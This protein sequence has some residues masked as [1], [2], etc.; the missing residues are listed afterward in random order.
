MDTWRAGFFDHAPLF[1]PLAVH[2]APLAIA[3]WPTLAAMQAVLDARGVV[4]GGG[5]P[6][7][8][9]APAPGRARAFE[10]RYEARIFLKGELAVRSHNWHDLF[11]VLVWLAF[12][13][14][15][16]AIN[17]R[18]YRALTDPIAP[19]DQVRANRG[20]TQDA[21]TLFD[22]G[23]VI[24]ASSEPDLLEMLRAFEWKRLFWRER[25]RVVE[26]MR[27]LLF[28][29]AVYEKALAPFV[30]ITGR[31][32]LFAVDP[33]LYALPLQAQMGALDARLA[34]LIADETALNTTR[35]LAPVP[36][37]GVPGWWPANSTEA[38]Y[39]NTDYFRAGRARKFS[40][41]RGVAR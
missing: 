1:A 31:G 28:G 4:G 8:V 9:V 17:A 20:P 18:H 15:K 40:A 21:L 11:N 6:L 27:W 25:P 16:A 39:D 32:L 2:G 30:G 37:L 33:S 19:R 41:V 29:H 12:P 26:R 38:F 23:G 35:D 34:A 22:E 7:T 14:A 3:D 13:R 10:E 24:V 5:K 36:I